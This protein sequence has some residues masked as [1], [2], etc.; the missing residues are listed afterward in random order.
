MNDLDLSLEVVSRSRQPLHYIWR[1]ISRK[2]LEIE[3]WL[4]RTTDRKWHY[5]LSNGHV[6]VD[7]WRHVILKGQTRDPNT[8]RAQY[9]ISKTTWA[10]DFKF[11]TRLC[12]GMLS[13]RTN[14]FPESGRG[15]GH[16]TPTIVGIRSNISSKLLELVTSNLVRGFVLPLLF[17]C[18]VLLTVVYCG[19]VRSAILA[20]AWL[21]DLLLFAFARINDTFSAD[22]CELWL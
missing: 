5:G 10:R 6:T 21:L 16:V 8:L 1:W 14:N 20:T 17:D 4:Q 22:F 2:P 9:I 19:A 15:L 12:M 3:A 13:R 11:G 18:R 7:R